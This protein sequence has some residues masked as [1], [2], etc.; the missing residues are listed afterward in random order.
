MKE[1]EYTSE[2]VLQFIKDNE[3]TEI[4]LAFCDTTGTLRNIPVTAKELPQIFREGKIVSE[5]SGLPGSTPTLYPDPATLV[6]LPWRPGYSQPSFGRVV[7]MFCN[8]GY[9]DGFESLKGSGSMEHILLV[10]SSLNVTALLA[11]L[12][13]GQGA[14]RVSS[15]SH[16][17]EARRLLSQLEYSLV[18][19]N[20]PL[21]DEFGHDLALFAA[22][23]TLSSVMLLVKGEAADEISKK[24]ENSGVMV[25]PKPVSRQM[26]YQALKLLQASADRIQDLKNENRKLQNKIEEIRM[27]DRAKCAMIQYLN[28]TE[29]QAHRYIEKQA[30]DLRIT[31]KEVAR[32]ILETY[33]T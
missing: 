20:T 33:D 3:I 22:K 28:M 14:S 10:S 32:G 25:V 2:E 23:N 8:I 18:I 13:K 11:D 19:V 9:P 15:A 7:Q 17:G 31:K 12:L 5:M 24:V 4:R 6:V 27:V 16:G 30:M 26:F 1:M 29:P 21:E